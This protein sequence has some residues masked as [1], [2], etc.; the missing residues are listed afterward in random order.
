MAL[1]ALIFINRHGTTPLGLN[2]ISQLKAVGLKRNFELG[3]TYNAGTIA[4]Q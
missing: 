4:C 2:N 1:L 3:G